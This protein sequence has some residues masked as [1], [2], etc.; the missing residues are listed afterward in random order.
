MFT[1]IPTCTYT[2]NSTAVYDISIEEPGYTVVEGDILEVC[3]T[4]TLVQGNA[5]DFM[6]SVN[7]HIECKLTI[8]VTVACNCS[9]YIISAT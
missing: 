6:L 3:V 2:G 4:A 8:R 1:I 9:L 5:F 7:L